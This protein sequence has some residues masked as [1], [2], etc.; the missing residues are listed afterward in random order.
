MSLGV[1]A[2]EELWTVVGEEDLLVLSNQGDIPRCSIDDR[3]N[4]RPVL[5][6]SNYRFAILRPCQLP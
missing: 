3:A 2:E 6:Y 4:G 1:T 5:E